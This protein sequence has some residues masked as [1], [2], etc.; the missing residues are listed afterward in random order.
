MLNVPEQVLN[1]LKSDSVRK[2]FKVHFPNDEHED[3]TNEN[4]VSESV[5][6]TES[7]FSGD[8]LK[9][10]ACESPYIEFETFGVGNLKGAKIECS[11]GVEYT[12]VSE[13]ESHEATES[14]DYNVLSKY[15]STFDL[16]E[17]DELIF[18]IPSELAQ[19]IVDVRV[20]YRQSPYDSYFTLSE[21]K[22]I[23]SIIWQDV[24]NT[25]GLF[26][27][28]G[29]VY[30]EVNG[31]VSDVYT[32]GIE[33]HVSYY[34]PLG[35]FIVDS[36]KKQGDM[37]HRKFVC[38]SYRSFKNV[39]I[40][41]TTKMALQQLLF[42]DQSFKLP[43]G[44]IID[45]M[46]TSN[47]EY[48]PLTIT[49][50]AYEEVIQIDNT[51]T[52][53]IYYDSVNLPASANSLKFVYAN[54]NDYT[55]NNFRNAINAL[56]EQLEGIYDLNDL[57]GK[58]YIKPKLA[59]RKS[60]STY[61]NIEG[62]EFYPWGVFDVFTEAI[63]LP[64]FHFEY[65]RNK[66]KYEI[67]NNPFDTLVAKSS[68]ID[69]TES[70]TRTFYIFRSYVFDDGTTPPIGVDWN[71]HSASMPVSR[72][73]VGVNDLPSYSYFAIPTQYTKVGS[74]PIKVYSLAQDFLENLSIQEYIE[75]YA[76]LLGLF[77]KVT[78]TGQLELVSINDNF[79]T[80]NDELTPH[81]YESLWYDDYESKPI[82]RI[83]C[84]FID[85]NNEPGYA[86]NSILY[87]PR[88]PGTYKTYNI[89][90]N[91]F[92]KNNRFEDEAEVISMLHTL[93]E[94]NIK[95]VSYMP[96]ELTM[97][98]RPDIE[99]GD[100]LTITLADG[101][102]ITGFVEKRTINGIQALSDNITSQDDSTSKD[103]IS[104]MASYDEESGVLRL[105]TSRIRR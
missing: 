18:H 50:D 78:R 82:R 100:V 74:Q 84:S 91:Y 40:P 16:S 32:I 42:A 105:F 72:V 44:S 17:G 67:I 6:F 7:I 71:Y 58:N 86:V 62:P 45:G 49:V 54:L 77:G 70:D 55:L 5:S 87:P 88:E 59:Y 64:Y 80:P 26:G 63:P 31:E 61:Y 1:A 56:R 101:T 46:F 15:N 104:L 81:D 20:N 60:S 48:E 51:R 95:D 8:E 38:Q 83:E 57:K 27:L 65:G 12:D 9:F 99:A 37:T 94:P 79:V 97:K 85:Q 66:Y 68:G 103:S 21:D 52:L 102:S 43:I 10:G 13:E 92:I 73:F 69:Y 35:V 34:I 19:Y 30:I 22:T 41:R 53:T 4:V 89:S 23:A 39:A 98:G 76:E 14:N 11:I 36:C 33:K 90:D 93:M 2:S 28:T 75:D 29:Q 25:K 3:I 47:A 24:F 96:M